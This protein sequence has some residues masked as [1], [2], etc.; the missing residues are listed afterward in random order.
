MLYLELRD[1][2]GA[3]VRPARRCGF[4]LIDLQLTFT[5]HEQVSR[6]ADQALQKV[7]AWQDRPLDPARD[8]GPAHSEAVP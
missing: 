6:I 8:V 5:A 1:E 2:G 3:V 4:V 7:R